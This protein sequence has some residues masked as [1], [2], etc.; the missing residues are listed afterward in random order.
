MQ[1]KRLKEKER[2]G[3]KKKE[4]EE[5]EPEAFLASDNDDGMDALD[6]IPDPDEIY[7]KE[8]SGEDSSDDE[9]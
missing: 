3:K 2:K 8:E 6:F 4:E 9:R 1:E 5:E 7:G